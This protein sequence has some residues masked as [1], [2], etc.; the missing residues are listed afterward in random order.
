MESD[1]QDPSTFLDQFT[2]KGGNTRLLMGI[3]KNTDASVIQ[4][5]GLSDY[6]KL[7]DDAN[8]ENQDVQNV[9][10]NMPLLKLG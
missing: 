9:T 2:I 1:Y 7:L 5:L 8:K 6:E 4:K 3:D 10:K